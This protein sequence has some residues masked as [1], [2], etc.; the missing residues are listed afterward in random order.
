MHQQRADAESF[1]AFVEMVEPRLRRAFVALYGPGVAR[2]ATSEA[3]VYAWEHWERIREM[4]SPV[5]FLYRV[6]QS[7][8]RKLRRRPPLF[9]NPPRSH[10]PWV[11]PALTA[12]LGELSDKQ[13]VTVVL[14]HCF[15]W[16]M[17]EV[18]ELL[19]VGLTTVQ[20]HEERAMVKLRREL[21]VVTDA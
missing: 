17:S 15:A 5:G 3:L 8:S 21:E 10:E 13:R 14:M 9:P 20:K 2:D 4:D 19:G 7:R 16:T 11:E 18:A 12:A 6:G 1:T